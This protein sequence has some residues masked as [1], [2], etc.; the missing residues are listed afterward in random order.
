[1][2]DDPP[3]RTLTDRFRES[4]EALK[5]LTPEQLKL[6]ALSRKQDEHESALRGI[7]WQ[8]NL[9]NANTRQ[10]GELLNQLLDRVA[11]L[12]AENAAQRAELGSQLLRLEE[13]ESAME[14]FREW[15][16]TKK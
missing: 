7:V 6:A 12:E 13:M 16:K 14:K 1:M 8:N 11:A 9:N 10:N 15:W 4:Q 3:P 2:P 5:K